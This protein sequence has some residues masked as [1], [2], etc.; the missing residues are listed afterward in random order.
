MNSGRGF[1]GSRLTMS[2]YV[3]PGCPYLP[4]LIVVV[5]RKACFC[6]MARD[7]PPTRD[8]S[9]P[10]RALRMTGFVMFLW[11]RF[12]SLGSISA[13]LPCMGLGFEAMLKSGSF[14]ASAV[15][16]LPR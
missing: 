9:S 12:I 15:K 10:A 3:N 14:L 8:T 11:I 2:V 16:G 6:V 13:H 4:K 1:L 7:K 5:R